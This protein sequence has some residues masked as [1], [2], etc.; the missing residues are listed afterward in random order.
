MMKKLLIVTAALVLLAM[1]ISP[2]LSQ[3][4]HGPAP[5][6]PPAGHDHPAPEPGPHAGPHAQMMA[7]LSQEQV[8][9]LENLHQIK[10]REVYPLVLQL[11]A[12]RAQLVSELGQE[13][14]NMGGVNQVIKE[15]NSLRTRIDQHRVDLIM[16]IREMRLPGDVFG[17]MLMSHGLRGFFGWDVMG[18]SMSGPGMMGPGMMG[19]GMMC[20]RMGHGAMGHGM[21]EGTAEGVE[22]DEEL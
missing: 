14:V 13:R 18:E 11:R 3:H 19:P 9:G 7:R 15:M 8:E 6:Q 5:D 21:S 16:R 2:V 10:F 17:S 20:P 1:F 22:Q 12:K 4:E